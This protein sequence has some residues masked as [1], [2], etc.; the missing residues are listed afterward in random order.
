VL[1]KWLG[2]EEGL[3]FPVDDK[4]SEVCFA[5]MRAIRREGFAVSKAKYLRV[6][7]CIL[8]VFSNHDQVNEL[9]EI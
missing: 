5:D 4:L 1:S 8:G 9:R 2:F 7:L 3:P 6:R